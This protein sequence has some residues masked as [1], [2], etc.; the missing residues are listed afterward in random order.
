[1]R[2]Y[3]K[4]PKGTQPEYFYEGYESTLL[5][6][7]RQPLITI[8]HGLSG[9]PGPLL[10]HNPIGETD[11]DLTRHGKDEPRRAHHRRRTRAR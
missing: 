6:A 5:R 2:E 4:P 3:P 11:G 10:G 1:M 8:P 9:R 7:P